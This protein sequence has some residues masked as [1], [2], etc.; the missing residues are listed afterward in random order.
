MKHLLLTS[1]LFIHTGGAMAA[2]PAIDELVAAYG[3]QGDA[4]RGA[5]LWTTKFTGNGQ[6]AERSCASCHTDQLRNSGKHVRTG[7][8]ILPLAPSANA[9]SLTDTKKIEKWLLRNCK[10]TLGRE[11]NAQEKSDLLSFMGRQ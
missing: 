6:P 5:Q 4:Q 1:L 2:T 9:D 10:W 7:K 8:S 11:C 3:S